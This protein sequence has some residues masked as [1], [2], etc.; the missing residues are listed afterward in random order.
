[1]WKTFFVAMAF[2]LFGISAQ[3]QVSDLFVDNVVQIDGEELSL[4]QDAIGKTAA[5]TT[6]QAVGEDGRTLR[7][8]GSGSAFFMDFGAQNYLWTNHHVVENATYVRYRLCNGTEFQYQADASDMWMDSNRDFASL[9]LPQ[10][11]NQLDTFEPADL[12]T[13][14]EGQSV[15]LI[16][17]PLGFQCSVSRGVLSYNGRHLG[18]DSVTSFRGDY[19]TDAALNPGNSGGV[20]VVLQDGEFKVIGMNTFIISP[21]RFNIGI[22]YIQPVDMLLTA[23]AHMRANGGDSFVS[24]LDAD[25]ANVSWNYWQLQARGNSDVLH[26]LEEGNR[27][28]A[29]TRVED[30]G[31]A[32]TL[33][34]MRGDIITHYNGRAVE[35]N[36]MLQQLIANTPPE[37]QA[38]ITILRHGETISLNGDMSFEETEAAHNS[39]PDLLRN[40][41]AFYFGLTGIESTVIPTR[42]LEAYL[43][44]EV[45]SSLTLTEA[46]GLLNLWDMS[47]GV[48]VDQ[49]A[50]MGPA[51]EAGITTHTIIDAVEINGT[52]YDVTSLER[53][54]YLLSHAEGTAV[55]LLVRYLPPESMLNNLPQAEVI[56]ITPRYAEK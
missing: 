5:I 37:T 1:M 51:H 54:E 33:G 41:P 8:S 6:I 56:T 52:W 30:D 23:H 55:P 47:H 18:R 31:A 10:F 39:L 36:M 32:A 34:L 29:V 9:S 16:G 4:L 22:G 27:G 40:V 17:S 45:Y 50:N 49:L 44:E 28:A 48:I 38:R 12:D 43:G 14:V 3:A 15:Y 21:T 7:A 42:A 53:L 46:Q 11:L 2:G 20:A 13:L 25:L 24:S 26:Y 19:Q 35:N